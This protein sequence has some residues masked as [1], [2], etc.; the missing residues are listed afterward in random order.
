MAAAAAAAAAAKVASLEL[1]MADAAKAARP[2]LVHC[3]AKG[4]WLLPNAV[5]GQIASGAAAET[6]APAGCL[7][8]VLEVDFGAGAGQAGSALA[9][10][11]ASSLFAA[12]CQQLAQH[13]LAPSE[14]PV[15]SSTALWQ[16]T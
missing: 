13:Q 12:L 16:T 15:N 14:A 3:V 5:A 4:W 7:G 9:A 1:V 6:A 2:V 11:T 8:L 10:E